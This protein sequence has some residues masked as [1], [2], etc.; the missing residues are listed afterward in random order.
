MNSLIC[1]ESGVI[2]SSANS[3][4]RGV[5]E[6]LHTPNNRR[7]L[8]MTMCFII[9]LV[10]KSNSRSQVLYCS[11]AAD[12]FITVDDHAILVQVL[13]KDQLHCSASAQ[14]QNHLIALHISLALSLFTLFHNN[15]PLLRLLLLDNKCTLAMC[16][17]STLSSCH[18]CV[19][20]GLAQSV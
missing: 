9:S 17:E 13:L 6:A 15:S 1:R 7:H 18:A 3:I 2:V 12:A 10:N 11:Q 8:M 19:G 16:D 5:M 4:R 20:L 14:P